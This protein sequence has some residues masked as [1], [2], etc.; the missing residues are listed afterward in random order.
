M[1]FHVGNKKQL[2]YRVEHK[3]LR[4]GPYSLGH[5]ETAKAKDLQRRLMDAHRSCSK[6]PPIIGDPAI[7]ACGC[8]SLEALQKWFKEF[9]NALHHA[10]YV[11]RVY[12]AEVY[13]STTQQLIYLKN[14]AKE[15][16]TIPILTNAA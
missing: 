7:H 8:S 10:G 4:H 6:H 12:E 15:I 5:M 9:W 13:Q 3:R 14:T 16:E 1:E 2:I 11:V